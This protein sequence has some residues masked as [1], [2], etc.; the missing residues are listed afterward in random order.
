MGCGVAKG[1]LWGSSCWDSNATERGSEREG[2]ELDVSWSAARRRGTE[3]RES[4]HAT[5]RLRHTPPTDCD[6]RHRPIAIYANN[7]GTHA[8]MQTDARDSRTD[9]RRD[10]WTESERNKND[11]RTERSAQQ[12]LRKIDGEG[13]CLSTPGLFPPWVSSRLPKQSTL[14]STEQT[15]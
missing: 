9:K 6:I 15:V 2:S 14:L 7:N 1:V 10:R 4:D 12:G 11:M 13:N 5:D 8:Q 3:E